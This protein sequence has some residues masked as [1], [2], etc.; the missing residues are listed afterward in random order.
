[1]SF[2]RRCC[3]CCLNLGSERLPTLL[4]ICLFGCLACVWGF[5][6]RLSKHFSA[7][8][9]V[10]IV[11]AGDIR[12]LIKLLFKFR[13]VLKHIES[14]SSLACDQNI[15][16]DIPIALEVFLCFETKR[17][18]K[19]VNRFFTKTSTQCASNFRGR[20]GYLT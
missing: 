11:C 3:L 14:G 15:K 8:H 2:N 6:C 1:M 13:N 12:L 9:S 10:V 20:T 7:V 18:D 19:H 17:N 16:E 4:S 5:V